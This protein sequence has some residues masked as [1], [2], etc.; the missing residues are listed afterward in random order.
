[1]QEKFR[2]DLSDEEAV[3]FFQEVLDESVRALFAQM[4]EMAHRWA[5]YWRK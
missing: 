2:L 3:R 4:M 1:M 5:Q